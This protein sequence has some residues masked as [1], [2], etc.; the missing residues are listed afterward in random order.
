MVSATALAPAPLR[1][2]DGP[3]ERTRLL[4][5]GV[6]PRSEGY[7]NVLFRLKD[8]ARVRLFEIT[9]INR[10]AWV[11][12]SGWQASRGRLA[13]LARFVSAHV[14]VLWCYLH[15]PA[16]DAVYVPYPAPFVLLLLSLLPRRRRPRWLVAD[17]FLSIYDTVVNDRGLLRRNGLPARFLHWAEALAY[18]VADRVLCDTR[19]NAQ[20]LAREF[21]VPPS[22]IRVAPLS[23]DERHFA[24]RAY[25]PR[26]AACRVLF[27]GSF[28]PL[29]GV[30]T[31]ARAMLMLVPRRDLTVR[32]IGDG[33]EAPRVE[34]LRPRAAE[35]LGWQRRW[36]SSAEL[37]EEIG[38]ADLCLGIFG[39][40]AKAQRVCPLKLY[41]YAAVGRPIITADTDWTRQVASSLGYSPFVT[42]PAG[43]P[44]ALARA[45]ADLAQ[46]HAQRAALAEAS[47][48]FYR[49]HLGNA[50][51][52][53]IVTRAL[54]AGHSVKAEE[55][56]WPE[57]QVL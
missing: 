56:E 40:T 28:V 26:G 47:R 50:R 42:V 21:G 38:A 24:S 5:L 27:V 13:A 12:R 14:R 9:E 48:R 18:R 30:E 33:Q 25:L 3:A 44:C 39:E 52:L 2:V 37:A 17:A 4:V 10:P 20:M 49:D 29:Q 46:D 51:G 11:A 31:V 15:S 19:L 35:A 7:P 54:L 34:R 57:Q 55:D 36:L 43:D 1:A 53:E 32:L 45:I 8:L 23:I 16:A 41:A 22:R 6:H